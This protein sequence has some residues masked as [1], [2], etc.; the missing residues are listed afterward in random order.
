MS[1]AVPEDLVCSVGQYSAQR[2]V[3]VFPLTKLLNLVWVGGSLCDGGAGM[4]L[5]AGSGLY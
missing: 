2:I 5:S 4:T 1:P 3:F